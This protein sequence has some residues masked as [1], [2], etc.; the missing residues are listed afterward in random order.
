MSQKKR[1]LFTGLLYLSLVIFG[2]IALLLI[3]S[4]C[5]V[6]D[7]NQYAESHMGLIIVWI[8]IELIIIG[9]EVILSLYLYKLLKVYHKN[10]SFFAF[11]FRIAVV[12]VMI[13]NVFYLSMILFNQGQN[14]DLFI[15]RHQDGIYIWQLF[16]SVH[17]FILGLIIFK[18][19][20]TLWK[21]L[22]V[23]LL[24]GAFGYLIDLIIALGNLDYQ[25][26]NTLSGFLLI[27]ITVVKLELV[28][29]SY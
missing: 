29:V 15:P 3:P 28:L 11:I 21:Y 10:L 18:Y 17:V 14:A 9:I 4:Q 6:I 8:L 5:D 1:S 12:V 13:V 25:T 2:P 26:L 7:I 23:V 19:N 22:G 24:I 27:F 20:K 16:F